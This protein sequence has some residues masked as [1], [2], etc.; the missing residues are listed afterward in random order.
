[1]RVALFFTG[2]Q[3]NAAM[4]WRVETE[5]GEALRWGVSARDRNGAPPPPARQAR[6][7]KAPREEH[8]APGAAA[9]PACTPRP[10][11]QRCQAWAGGTP[12][13]AAPGDSGEGCTPCEAL[14][15]CTS[16]HGESYGVRVMSKFLKA[17]WVCGGVQVCEFACVRARARALAWGCRRRWNPSVTAPSI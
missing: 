11:G 7:W 10:A 8:S 3:S 9:G 15:S 6:T 12:A 5:C 1:M 14:P 17:G 16:L 13:G 4:N 2:A